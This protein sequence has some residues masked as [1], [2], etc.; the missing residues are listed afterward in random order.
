VFVFIGTN[1]PA[2][3]A[4]HP[5]HSCYYTID[6]D[7]LVRGAMVAANWACSMLAE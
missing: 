2:I 7:M 4:D 6:E 1:N 5:Q 3:G